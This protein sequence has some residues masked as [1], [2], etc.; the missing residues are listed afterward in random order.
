MILLND[1]AYGMIKRKQHAMGFQDFGLDLTNPDFKLLAQ[2]FGAD[3]QL[4]D[5]PTKLQEA[6]K[7]T[8]MQPGVHLI[9]VPIVYPAEVN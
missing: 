3:Y 4:A 7:K 9:E 8:Y 5:S 1:N 6:L 2:S